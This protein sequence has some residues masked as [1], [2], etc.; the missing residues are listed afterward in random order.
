MKSLKK[1][2][3]FCLGVVM[4]MMFFNSCESNEKKEKRHVNEAFHSLEECINSADSDTFPS[5]YT[6]IEVRFAS[7]DLIHWSLMETESN[8][9]KRAAETLTHDRGFFCNGSMEKSK[10]RTNIPARA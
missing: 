10:N 2:L 8:K 3:L 4:I 9:F 1:I 5:E 6:T 7:K